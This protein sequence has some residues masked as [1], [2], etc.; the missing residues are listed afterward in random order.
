MENISYKKASW[1]LNSRLLIYVDQ[2]DIIQPNG[3]KTRVFLWYFNVRHLTQFA[4]HGGGTTLAVLEMGFALMYIHSLFKKLRDYQIG[5]KSGSETF[6]LLKTACGDD[7]LSRSKVCKWYTR[8]NKNNF[9]P[10]QDFF[11]K[12][13]KIKDNVPFLVKGE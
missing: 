9:E 13:S 2:R 10:C 6:E 8:F 11:Y 5:K 1:K 12:L 4:W 3:F 7:C